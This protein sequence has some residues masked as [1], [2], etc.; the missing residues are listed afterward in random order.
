MEAAARS[1]IDSR[2]FGRSIYRATAES[3]AQAD[4]LIAFCGEAPV[5]MMIARCPSGALDA[6]Q[7]LE[8]FGFFLCDTLVYFRGAPSRV[9]AAQKTDV[10]NFVEAD[11]PELERIARASF[12]AFGGHYHRDPRLDGALATEGYVEWALSATRDPTFDVLVAAPDGRPAGFLTLRRGSSF[13]IVLNGV[14]PEQQRGGVYDRLVKAA[15]ASARSGGATEIFSS[16]QL[17]NLGP[18]K[19]WARNGLEPAESFYTL[20]W[21]RP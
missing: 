14:A 20:H 7:R 18:Q 17:T 10:R 3:A 1:E 21:W 9:P 6:V 13:E 8:A 16:T 4:Q 5:E 2:R 11:R 12:M 19:V 15:G